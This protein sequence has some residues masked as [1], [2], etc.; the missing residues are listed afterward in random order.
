MDQKAL[1]RYFEHKRGELVEAVCALVRVESVKGEKA[2]GAPYGPGPKAALDAALKLGK[3]MGFSVRS[4]EDRV[5]AIDLQDGLPRQL[6][7]LAHMDVVPAGDGWTVTEPFKPFVCD[8]RIYGRGSA[9]DKGPAMAALFAMRAV[10]EL[11]VPL[12][13]GVRLILGTDEENGAADIPYY[14][15][16][17]PEAP[18][19]FTPDA[20]FP[21]INVEKGGMQA[22][23]HARWEP[24]PD[25]PRIRSL[26]AGLRGNMIPQSAA[27]ELEGF[28]RGE[29]Q[30][31]AT[32]HT[33]KSGVIFHVEESAE[34]SILRVL[35][36][37]T[38]GHAS[39]PEEGN[40]ALTALLELAVR[41][42]AA[43]GQGSRALRH[44]NGMFPHGDWLG[45]AAGVAMSDDVAGELTISLNCLSYE[46]GKLDGVYDCRAPLCA[47]D[48]NVRDVLRNRFD[49]GGIEME[50][51][52]MTPPHYV[53]ADTP[54]VRTLL[55][56]YE[57]YTGEKGRTIAIGGGTYVHFLKNGVAFGCA[58]QDVNNR[59]HGADEFVVIDQLILSAKIFA[60]VIIELCS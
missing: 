3:D 2:P 53:P 6:D 11:G 26:H 41:L 24:E 40:N 51:R 33:Q 9:D 50:Q 37:G 39:Q 17:E 48:G 35:A 12:K 32:L 16:A 56:C 59:M 31:L 36:E 34:E 10:R 1:E 21:V 47:S 46:D 52:A 58:R 38:G 43:E 4:Y 20:D 5:G 42:P 57:Q 30:A 45:R 23:F 15:A 28:S 54:F 13:R 25:L 44:L 27:A 55:N 22:G 14:Y 19:T 49:A 7:I 18:M 8:G 29:I 60:Q